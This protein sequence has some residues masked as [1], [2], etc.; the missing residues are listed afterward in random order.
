MTWEAITWNGFEQ[1]AGPWIWND[2]E[3]YYYSNNEMQYVLDRETRT[4][5]EKKW[6]GDLTEIHGQNVWTNGIN[7]YY[8]YG[9]EQYMLNK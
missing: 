8:S 2:G 3:N 7:Y 9:N 4:W 5:N 1:P 6:F